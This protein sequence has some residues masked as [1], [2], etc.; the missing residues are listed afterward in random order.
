[1]L[2]MRSKA[3]WLGSAFADACASGSTCG[4]GGFVQPPAGPAIWFSERF[5]TADFAALSI[6]LGADLQK[7]IAFL[8]AFAQV[9]ILRILVKTCSNQRLNLA[10]VSHA[11]NT[12]AEARLNSLFST[13]YPMNL[14]L[15]KVSLL[16]G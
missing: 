7:H 10:F 5:S 1:M 2:S 16:L 4:I 8:E 6:Q 13:K 14:L 15:E 9:G 3:K 12:G 11:D